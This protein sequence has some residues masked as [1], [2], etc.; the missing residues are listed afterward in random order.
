MLLRLD[1]K[2]S[3]GVGETVFLIIPEQSQLKK[4]NQVT[5]IVYC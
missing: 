4:A 2:G 5:C 1:S 3:L